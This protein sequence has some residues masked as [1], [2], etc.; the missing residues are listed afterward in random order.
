MK[1]TTATILALLTIAIFGGVQA[2]T[3]SGVVKTRGRMVKGALV[4]GTPLSGATVQVDGCQTILAKDGKFSFPVKGGRYTLK[5]VTKQGYSLVDAEACRQYQYSKNPLTIVMEQPEQQRSDQL[6]TERKL[7]RELQRRIQ[8]REDEIDALNTSVEDKNRMLV[9]LNK[10][11]EENEKI[12]ETIAKYYATLDYDQL[13]AFQRQ[14]SELLENGSLER[15]DSL[16]R[17]RGDMDGRISRIQ[18]EQK[19]LA[20][21][22]TAQSMRQ[23]RLDESK[24]GTQKKL[25]AI[26]A[27]CFSFHQRFLM[28]HQNDSAAYYL[29]L[30]ASLDTTNMQWQIDAGYFRAN[31]LS[32]FQTTLPYFQ[33]ACRLS[34]ALYGE[35][36]PYTARAYTAIGYYHYK[37]Y[38]FDTALVY[39]Q[40]ALNIFSKC[41]D[42]KHIEMADAY[43]NIANVYS[44]NHR[45]DE[46]LENYGK[47][48]EI[49]NSLLGENN[50]LTAKAYSNMAILY[51]KKGDMDNFLDYSQKALDANNRC[52]GEKE[53]ETAIAYYLLGRYYN[54]KRQPQKAL[55]YQKKVL[56]IDKEFFGDI[57][58]RTASLLNEM[59]TSYLQVGDYQKSLQL[60]DEALKAFEVIYGG[61]HMIMAHILG[62]IAIVQ[63]Y[64]KEYDRA[65]E[66]CQKAKEMLEKINA[67]ES[68]FATVYNIGAIISQAKGNYKEAV[69][70]M[71]KAL[72]LT[73]NKFGEKSV[74]LVQIYNSLGESY[75]ELGE[76]QEALECAKK[77]LEIAEK[78]LGSEHKFTQTAK[79]N[80]KKALQKLD[81]QQK[82]TKQKNQK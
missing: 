77:A 76:Y 63:C 51:Q 72:E 17:T 5:S 42:G 13:D 58:A 66:N 60:Y 26:A 75:L 33:N 57:S 45:N 61:K 2:Q 15:A 68:E 14:V 49:A 64:Q 10:E 53:A 56:E 21:A 20:E 6:A 62:N 59:A 48:I 29:E 18:Q 11:R 30:R 9:Q 69:V 1:K 37:K 8:Q 78:S 80:E 74:H 71:N 36:N 79:E 27:D 24:A 39:Y 35:D 19:A 65:D 55:E 47:V 44:S 22:Q 50:Y 38:N 23:K 16:L 81:E 28:A 4:P 67:P 41:Y 7:R 46:S 3:Q 34:K 54:L 40:R 32:D 31:F 43:L 70:N 82:Q 52:Y 25:E 12:I 73:K